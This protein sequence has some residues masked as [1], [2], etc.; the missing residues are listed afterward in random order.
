MIPTVLLLGAIGAVVLPHRGREAI[1]A[2]AIAWVVLV[3]FDGSG[4]NGGIMLVGVA[5]A[6]AVNAAAGF[7]AAR[8]ARI[9]VNRAA[10]PRR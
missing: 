5:V 4:V 9:A 3:A 10:L 6:G 1:A 7:A 2:C 8:M